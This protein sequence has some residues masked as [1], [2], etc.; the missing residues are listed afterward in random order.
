MRSGYS[1][2]SERDMLHTVLMVSADG[3]MST[4]AEEDTFMSLPTVSRSHPY[5][6]D[7]YP[8]A[9]ISEKNPITEEEARGYMTAFTSLSRNE[10]V[11]EQRRREGLHGTRV[12][13]VPGQSGEHHEL[14]LAA[15]SGTMI[16]GRR[17]ISSRYHAPTDAPSKGRISQKECMRLERDTVLRND[18]PLHCKIACKERVDY[19][20]E[21]AVPRLDTYS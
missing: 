16:N 3:Q 4:R 10:W 7:E 2:I 13:E 5:T 20:G 18:K 14:A 12:S 21:P 1:G 15:D 17:R 11:L 9:W 8:T 6:Y 19:A